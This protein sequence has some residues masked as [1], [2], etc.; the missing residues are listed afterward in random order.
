MTW[1]ET[2]TLTGD[3][4]SG[5]RGRFTR[6][7]NPLLRFT[8]LRYSCEFQAALRQTAR[9]AFRL[10]FE[11]EHDHPLSRVTQIRHARQRPEPTLLDLLARDG[12]TRRYARNVILIQEGDRGDTIYIV[13]SGRIKAYVES[14]AGREFVLGIYGA[15]EYVGEMSLDGGPRSASVITIEPTVCSVVS[16]EVLTSFIQ[17]HPEFAFD[18]LSRVIRKARMATESVR[19]LALLDVYGRISRLLQS[20]AVATGEANVPM[21]ER[22][23]HQ[24]IANRVGCSR[25]MVSRIIKDLTIGGYLAVGK[26]GIALLRQLPPAW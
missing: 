24:E 13:L 9:L 7:R 23:S 20:E 4:S 12:A 21:V 10:T 18:L 16:R 11:A 26:T 25:E 3:A 6:A 17:R 15:G 5:H 8:Q 2:F 22:L 1:Q 14:S 19:S